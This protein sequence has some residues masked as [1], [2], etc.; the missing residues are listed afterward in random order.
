MRPGLERIAISGDAEARRPVNS[1]PYSCSELRI[2]FLARREPPDTT[3]LEQ[4]PAHL[5]VA[6]RLRRLWYLV[7]LNTVPS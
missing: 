6:E 4:I 1:I 7:A 2:Q 3:C 5:G